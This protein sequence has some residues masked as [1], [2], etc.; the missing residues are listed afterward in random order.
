MILRKPDF[1]DKFQCTASKC[2]DTCCV[3]WEIDIDKNSQ[4]MYRKVV[5]EFPDTEKAAKSQ[6]YLDQLT[7]SNE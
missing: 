7:G 5:D 2:S 3:G 4:E 1:Y 6:G